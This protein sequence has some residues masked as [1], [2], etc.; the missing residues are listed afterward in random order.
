MRTILVLLVLAFSACGADPAEPATRFAGEAREVIAIPP[1]PLHPSRVHVGDS[2]AL[3]TS[4]AGAPCS[5]S[6]DSKGFLG[7]T[8]N[9]PE[10]G[11]FGAPMEAEEEWVLSFRGGQV[12]EICHGPYELYAPSCAAY[13]ARP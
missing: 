9:L 3:A 6:S 12:F 4:L 1:G 11:I 10:C 8:Y 7:W 5:I 2:E 13:L